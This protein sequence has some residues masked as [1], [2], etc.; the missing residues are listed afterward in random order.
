M[1]GEKSRQCLNLNELLVTNYE[2]ADIPPTIMRLWKTP[3]DLW[4]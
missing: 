3:M 4:R 1:L 2:V